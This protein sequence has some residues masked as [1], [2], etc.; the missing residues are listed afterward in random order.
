MSK[1]KRKKYRKEPPK[2]GQ[3]RINPNLVDEYDD[4][5]ADEFEEFDEEPEAEFHGEFEDAYR[6]EYENADDSDTEDAESDEYPENGDDGEEYF[7][8][9]SE[10]SDADSDDNMSDLEAEAM[11][12]L[13]EEDTKVRSRKKK[14]KE[15]YKDFYEAPRSKVVVD[16]DGYDDYEPKRRKRKLWLFPV[17]LLAILLIGL[18]AIAIYEYNLVYTVAHVE[19]GVEVGVYDFLK[20]PDENAYFAEDSEEIDVT[21]PGE[22]HLR[23]MT[24]GIPHNATLYV[25]DTVAPKLT[26]KD[27]YGPLGEVTD[28]SELVDECIDVTEVSFSY[29]TEPD[30]GTEGVQNV[31]VVA[32]DLGGNST[33]ATAKL[34]IL[35]V[36]SSLDVEVGSA[37]PN[38]NDFV[39]SGSGAEYVDDVSELDMNV[40]A[41]YDVKIKFNGKTYNS[42]INTIDTVSPEFEAE[43]INGYQN[44]HYNAEDYIIRCIDKTAVKYEYE[45]EPD[46]TK[47]GEQDVTIVATDEGGNTTTKSAKLVLKEDT[48]TP[49]IEG[50]ADFTAYLGD[51]I[52]YK[53]GV[54]VKDK[55][56]KDLKLEVDTSK[57]DTT[58]EGVYP[59]TYIATD[60][61]G[62]SSEVTVN[63][64]L[65]EFSI[66][67]DMVNE[68]V[69]KALAACI[70]D[71][72]TNREKCEA[73]YA[74]M[75]NHIGFINDSEKGD[76]VRATYEGLSGGQGDCY[77]FASTA[78]MML[79]RAGI[80]NMDIERIPEG[81]K[82]HYWNLVDLED[83]HGWYHFD[84]TPRKG[85]PNLCL[86]DDATITAY[87]DEHGH[88]HN[89]DR[90]KYPVIP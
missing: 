19:A 49:V 72:M 70:N 12:E 2:R 8:E 23:I 36:R 44:A 15:Q 22:Y 5:D 54:T 48:D 81:D 61:S 13:E 58:K 3:N 40:L 6:E 78:K 1:N 45:T 76:Y 82:L 33:I 64:T 34:T 10:Y 32:T 11:A 69:D 90:T 24:G 37:V 80:I 67:V 71:S 27:G 35:P 16:I 87:S 4:F 75:Q 86:L 50:A 29:E 43:T 77:V 83:G 55:C 18:A 17:T 53:S 74:Y 42:K 14:R 21:V 56:E 38:A 26:V 41:S 60:A 47:L 28:A 79:T 31:K 89:Y 66:D 63:M 30:F 51:T 7:E 9:D 52:A 59:V 62:H 84:T 46:F 57:V 73:I 20:N 65:A 88:P 39:V 85:R 68:L 25:E